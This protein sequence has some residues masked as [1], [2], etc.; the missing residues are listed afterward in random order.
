MEVRS[1]LLAR[2]LADTRVATVVGTSSTTSVVHLGSGEA[3]AWTRGDMFNVDEAA[4]TVNHQA[5]AQVVDIDTV[6]DTLTVDPPLAAAPAA[7]AQL[8]GGAREW[9]RYVSASDPGMT[10]FDSLVD[11]PLEQLF[12][13]AADSRCVIA[14]GD[15]QDEP[16]LFTRIRSA[17]LLVLMGRDAAWIEGLTRRLYTLLQKRHDALSVVGRDVQELTVQVTELGERKGRFERIVTVQVVTSDVIDGTPAVADDLRETAHA[18]LTQKITDGLGAAAIVRR[19]TYDVDI[20]RHLPS[21]ISPIPGRALV[22]LIEGDGTG[23]RTEKSSE[24]R[25]V[26]S[27]LE[28]RCWVYDRQDAR[29]CAVLNTLLNRLAAAMKAVNTVDVPGDAW[30]ERG[31]RFEFDG[32]QMLRGKQG[33]PPY[34][35]ASV[36]AEA[37]YREA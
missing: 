23:T 24:R 17:W 8:G 11:A 19:V 7:G 9:P 2:I 22:V 21:T 5:V 32:H 13:T 25:D 3:A 28:V 33:A 31:Y 15:T 36:Q 16:E 37:S 26:K 18:D 12:A 29:R 20:D 4:S 30:S 35:G 14:Y 6:A 34:A 10:Y 1:A 27:Q